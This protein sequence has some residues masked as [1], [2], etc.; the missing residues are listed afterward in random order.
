MTQL[1]PSPWTIHLTITVRSAR[2][3]D[4]PKLEWYG[5]Y[6]HF[7]NLFRRAYREQMQDRRLMLIADCGSFPIGYVF[8]QLQSTHPRVADGCSRA[9]LYSFRVMEHFQNNGIG[10]RLLEEAEATLTQRGFQWTTIAVAKDN[11]R[12]LRLY[13]RLGYRIFADD[14]GTW[15]YT[16]HQGRVRQ[17]DEPSWIL[18]K[19]LSLR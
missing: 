15:S 1:E 4:L 11:Q 16:D 17:I 13:E 18:E 2:A 10:T 19:N 5:Q 7:R 6:A 12:A 3:E 14:P 9:Y 8:I